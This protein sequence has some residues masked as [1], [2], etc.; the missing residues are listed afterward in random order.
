MKFEDALA[1]VLEHEGGFVDDTRDPGGMTC[2]GVTRTVW[3]EWVGHPVTEKEMKALTP[4]KVAPLYKRK[5]WD[6]VKADQLPDGLDYS[7]F[8]FAVNSGP[9]RAIKLLQ[10]CVDVKVDGDIGPVT[11]AAIKAANPRK[12]VFLYNDARLAFLRSL[13]HWNVYGN[14][15]GKRVAEVTQAAIAVA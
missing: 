15:W 13:P 5:Y 7:V 1:K 14:G 9:G 6:K 4:E 11:I 12:L 10:S 8:D 3:Q 2:L